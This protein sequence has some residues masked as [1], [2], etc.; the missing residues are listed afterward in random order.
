MKY[1]RLRNIT[2]IYFIIDQL[3]DNIGPFSIASYKAI[4]LPPI[5]TAKVVAL[6]GDSKMLT[7]TLR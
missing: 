3:I 1:L 7:F 2:K 4:A 6:K 5:A